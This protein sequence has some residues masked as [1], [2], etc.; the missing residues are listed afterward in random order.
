[1]INYRLFAP[2][3][4]AALVSAT[5]GIPAAFAAPSYPPAAEVMAASI[6][7]GQTPYL[8]YEFNGEGAA[9]RAGE[10]MTIT[11]VN[12]AG[13]DYVIETVTPKLGQQQTVLWPGASYDAGLDWPG[14]E[15]DSAGDWVRT[16]TDAG[17]FTTVAGGVTVRFGDE[18]LSTTVVYAADDC[19]GP[20]LEAGDPPVAVASEYATAPTSVPNTGASV[21]PLVGAG[22][23]ALALGAGLTLLGRRRRA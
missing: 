15:Q 14:W 22:I 21:G 3:G 23:A 2:L 5:V 6:C 11:F 20:V 4:A 12:T 9:P 8:A 7:D 17:A 13:D 10:P 18:S 16:S 19:S 1:M